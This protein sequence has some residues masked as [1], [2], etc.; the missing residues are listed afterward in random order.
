MIA[1]HRPSKLNAFN[2]EKFN[3]FCIGDGIKYFDIG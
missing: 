2:E 3:L 1:H